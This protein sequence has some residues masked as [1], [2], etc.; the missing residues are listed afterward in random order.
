MLCDVVAGSAGVGVTWMLC[1]VVAGSAGGGV[2]PQPAQNALLSMVFQK[3]ALM[4]GKGIEI[5]PEQVKRE[6]MAASTRGT[7]QTSP[8]GA[9]AGGAAGCLAG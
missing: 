5:T 3:L 8:T 2:L 4:K 1:Y 6:L 7:A 9:A